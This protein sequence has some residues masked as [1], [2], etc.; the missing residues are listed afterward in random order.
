MAV[1]RGGRAVVVVGA[2]GA[3]RPGRRRGSGGRRGRR[4]AAEGGSRRWTLPEPK[5][6][7]MPA[8]TPTSTAVPAATMP[9]KAPRDIVSAADAPGAVDGARG[10]QPGVERRGPAG[11]GQDQR[12]PGEQEDDVGAGVVGV[13]V[14]GDGQ[15]QAER[16]QHA[17]DG[18]HPGEQSEQGA[19]ADGHLGDGDELRRSASTP[20]SGGRAG[21]RS[22]WCGRSRPAGRGWR[23]GSSSGRS[24]DW[25]ASGGRRRRRSHRG[26]AAAGTRYHPV[27]IDPSAAPDLHM[28]A[29]CRRRGRRHLRGS[30]AAACAPTR[31]VRSHGRLTHARDVTRLPRAADRHRSGST[32]G[33]WTRP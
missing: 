6:R 16:D 11:A 18:R 13:G 27:A 23:W 33:P 8:T 9:M 5:T 26:T 4:G 32:I 2:A 24:R 1:P 10:G 31:G 3:R 7:P 21:R 29:R 12:R 22:G 15:E 17:A 30:L 19:H 20:P 25:P 28:S 14:E